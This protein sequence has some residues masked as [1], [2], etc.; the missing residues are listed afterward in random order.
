VLG[1]FYT[2]A[3]KQE[4]GGNLLTPGGNLAAKTGKASQTPGGNLLTPGGNLAAKTG[5]ASQTPGGNLAALVWP[6]TH[7]DLL[8][9]CVACVAL[10]ACASVP[11]AP[12]LAPP[13]KP[14][15]WTVS[16][17]RNGQTLGQTHETYQTAF[18]ARREAERSYPEVPLSAFAFAPLANK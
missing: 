13:A 10:A 8:T 11:A 7:F 5:K 18:Y 17:K 6:T 9:V 15:H 14:V 12:E 16:D 4:T 2:V 1:C 3:R